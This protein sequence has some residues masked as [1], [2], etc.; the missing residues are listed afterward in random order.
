[1]NRSDKAKWEA[2]EET[3]KKNRKAKAK[4]EWREE[5]KK[6]SKEKTKRERCAVTKIRIKKKRRKL[7]AWEREKSEYTGKGEKYRVRGKV[8]EE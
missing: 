1:M 8:K 7:S 3:K 6:N 5:T 4:R 2:R